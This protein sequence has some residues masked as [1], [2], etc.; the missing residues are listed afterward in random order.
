MN[1]QQQVGPWFRRVAQS[2]LITKV[3]AFCCVFYIGIPVFSSGIIIRSLDFAAILIFS[4][5]A[6]LCI[7]ANAWK[8]KGFLR[9]LAVFFIAVF[10]S[11]L[12]VCIRTSN[13]HLNAWLKAIRFS[14]LLLFG[15]AATFWKERQTKCFIKTL[16]WCGMGE[17]TFSV[18][19]YLFQVEL[20]CASQTFSKNGQLYYR[21]SGFVKDAASFAFLCVALIFI[22]LFVLL[23][24]QE[25]TIRAVAMVCFVLNWL[26]LW[27]SRTRVAIFAA[28]LIF[29]IEIIL[30]KF[31]LYCGKDVIKWMGKAIIATGI[32][33]GVAVVI[34]NL[35][36]SETVC[37]WMDNLETA[38]RSGE[39]VWSFLN[40]IL[41]E[42]LYIWA[43]YVSILMRTPF[44]QLLFGSG[45]Y[46]FEQ[47]MNVISYAA[48]EIVVG[49]PT[50]NMLLNTLVGMGLFGWVGLVGFVSSI[51]KMVSS[52]GVLIARPLL[53]CQL[54]F[55]L[56]DDSLSMVN[57]AAILI[58][59]AVC[60][61]YSAEFK[62]IKD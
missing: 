11:V 8:E 30:Y 31:P 5:I 7:A 16:I 35:F 9:W 46:V 57:S 53:L 38:I 51:I 42:R 32:F 1:Y 52:K 26:G 14:Y 47:S 23:H 17:A 54:M 15:Y 10:L 58:V 33:I 6:P 48:G 41:S 49:R 19:M 3:L 20:F 43:Q 28:F 21:A 4:V 13:I 25:K 12:L 37:G 56:V 55:M 50:H 22:S 59:V 18:L 62:R 40:R 24:E 39:T 27:Y 2:D 36:F 34:G 45:Y 29:L 44:L 60:A 61:C